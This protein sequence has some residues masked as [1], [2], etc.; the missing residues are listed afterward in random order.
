MKLIK[1]VGLLLLLFTF[2]GCEDDPVAPSC[3]NYAVNFGPFYLKESTVNLF[4]YT[5]A[6]SSLVFKNAL[7]EELV[8]RLSYLIRDTS[9]Y[10]TFAECPFDSTMQVPSAR[11][12]EE[13][14]A[15]FRNDS[16][17]LGL[18]MSF[19]TDF[20][21]IGEEVIGE[22]DLAYGYFSN[23]FPIITYN[24]VSL[25]AHKSGIHVTYNNNF[26]STI[27]LGEKTFENVYATKSFPNHPPAYIMYMNYDIG[28]VGFEITS[29]GMLWVFDRIE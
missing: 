4:P 6:D 2:V 20:T 9:K 28:I 26:Y 25:I 12:E 23:N 18:Q 27:T 15:S 17:D 3:E 24:L 10:L 1:L 5:K 8:F 14:F 21:Y 22:A 11:A 19:Q 16:L 13:I 7:N 29:T